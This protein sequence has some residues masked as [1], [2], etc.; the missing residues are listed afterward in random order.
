MAANDAE[1]DRVGQPKA[2]F[3][4]VLLVQC[5]RNFHNTVMKYEFKISKEKQKIYPYIKIKKKNHFTIGIV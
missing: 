1:I 4:Q 3:Q 5:F 2:S